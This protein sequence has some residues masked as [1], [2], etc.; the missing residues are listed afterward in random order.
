MALLTEAQ[1][2]YLHDQ[3]GD[4]ADETEMQDRFDRLGDVTLVVTEMLQRRL[5]NLLASPSSFS[6]SGE[7]S[8]NTSD[9]IKA[10]QAQLAGVGSTSGTLS[11]VRV[12]KPT[13][14]DER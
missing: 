3:L 10:L 5:A 14:S 13:A 4:D 7:Y 6:V 8:Q 1:L 12:V 11:T 2:T 9:N